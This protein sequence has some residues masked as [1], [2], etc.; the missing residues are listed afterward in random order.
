MYYTSVDQTTSAGYHTDPQFYAQA[1]NIAV[2]KM[3]CLFDDD[4]LFD[5][6]STYK[7][8]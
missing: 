1:Y 2:T 7:A 3:L 4:I 5:L 6:F 8:F